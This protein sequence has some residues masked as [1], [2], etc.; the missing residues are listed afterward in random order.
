MRG[1]EASAEPKLPGARLSRPFL[2]GAGPATGCAA[3]TR[4]AW[5]AALV[6]RCARSHVSQRE[7]R[8]GSESQ[9]DCIDAARPHS[10]ALRQGD[11]MLGIFGDRL[12]R[13]RARRVLLKKITITSK[14]SGSLCSGIPFWI[15]KPRGAM[16]AIP[17]RTRGARHGSRPNDAPP[18]GARGYP[19]QIARAQTR[20]SAPALED[21]IA[22]QQLPL[23][24]AWRQQMPFFARRGEHGE[25]PLG[26]ALH[27]E[28]HLSQ[29][30]WIAIAV[31]RA[32]AFRGQPKGW[33]RS[34]AVR[35]QR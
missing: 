21:G 24:H 8:W 35:S 30:P 17:V 22:R 9:F 1:E 33:R 6:S 32:V 27:N 23:S 7:W 2:P 29:M 18:I 16:A 3:A 31:C 13:L 15:K 20:I 11:T 19:R 14:T 5:R 26:R 25:R 12:R 28:S 4:C 34:D 10:L